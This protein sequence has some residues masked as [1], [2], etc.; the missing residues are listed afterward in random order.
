M[1]CIRCECGA[2]LPPN[3]TAK[4]KKQHLKSITHKRGMQQV[5][6]AEE[7]ARAA[8]TGNQSSA[9]AG[10]DLDIELHA[11]RE[12]CGQDA[13]DALLQP[14]AVNRQHFRVLCSS[15]ASALL[16]PPVLRNPRKDC[17]KLDR[18]FL[19]AQCGTI[20]SVPAD[21]DEALRTY[22]TA[23]RDA[24]PRVDVEEE[25]QNV[26]SWSEAR[27]ALQAA[28]AAGRRFWCTFYL[29]GMGH[30][31]WWPKACK[32]PDGTGE[33][34]GSAKT[35]DQVI[36]GRGRTGI[37]I[38][39]DKYDVGGDSGRP[40]R[41]L[42]STCITIVK[43]RKHVLM[44]PPSCAAASCDSCSWFADGDAFPLSPSPELLRRLVAAGGY[45]FS[46]E[47][48]ASSQTD[49]DDDEV[50][51]LALFTPAGWFHWL[52]GDAPANNTAA[53]TEALDDWHVVFGGS[54]PP[55]GGPV[56]A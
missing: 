50:E 7:P 21:L 53:E 3:A 48:L 16:P 28:A 5:S 4:Q 9:A 27:R 46:M 43:G 34:P 47:P 40:S 45:L 20:P 51:G 10:T 30:P 38:H 55:P 19:T 25:D 22:F 12:L 13:P 2:L 6:Q 14:Y 42:C 18:P 36:V 33:G 37:G 8:D 32:G 1:E 29:P 15:E 35:Q 26:G 49:D 23:R 11:L 54:Y 24:H 52:V 44:L 41:R 56:A 31:S 39:A 17:P